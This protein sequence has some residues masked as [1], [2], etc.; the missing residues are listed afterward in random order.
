[1][2]VSLRIV[3]IF[4]HQTDIPYVADMTVADVLSAA[5]Q[6]PGGQ[7]DMFGFDEGQLMTPGPDK[8]KP[9]IT[10]FF[11]NYPKGVTSETSG[12]QYPAGEYSLGEDLQGRPAYTVW[13]YYVFSSPL[14][15]GGATYIPNSPRIETFAEA[16]VPDDGMVVW[17]LCSIL[18]GPNPV[19]PRL[20]RSLMGERGKVMS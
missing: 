8:G 17:R 19:P 11:A 6:S 7:A 3:G 13:Q 14:Q 10:S 18:A 9:S 12:I 5:R 2:T 15:G 4:Y 16:K 1:M 20:R